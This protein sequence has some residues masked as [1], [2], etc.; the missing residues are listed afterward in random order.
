MKTSIWT[1]L[2]DLISPRRCIACGNRLSPNESLLCVGCDLELDVTPFSQSPYD[3]A[4][5][6]LF[7]GQFPVE[8]ASAWFYYRSHG[9]P[10]K[11]IYD[12]KYHGDAMLGEDIGEQIAVRHQPQGFFDGIDAIVP[13][14][15]TGERRRQRGYNQ[16]E[17]LARGISIVT[18]LPIYNKV[19]RRVQ[20]E[21]SQTH[22]SAWERRENVSGVFHLQAPEQIRG[23]HLLLVDDIV[24]TGSTI[25]ACAQ[26]LAQAEDVRLSVLAAGFARE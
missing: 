14:P 7:W 11:M 26:A 16:S 23:K 15:I 1:N 10:S 19:V 3:N 17:M 18:R 24:T 21:K 9:A 12:L 13:V 22:Q 20:F 8:K 4:L 5:A 25:I 6:R 2:L